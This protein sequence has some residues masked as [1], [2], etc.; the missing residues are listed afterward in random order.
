MTFDPSRAGEGSSYT[1][2]LQWYFDNPFIGTSHA[3]QDFAIGASASIDAAS[4]ANTRLYL[5]PSLYAVRDGAAVPLH[6]VSTISEVNID[7]TTVFDTSLSALDTESDRL[8]GSVQASIAPTDG[9]WSSERTTFHIEPYGIGL[10]S[11]EGV[12][13]ETSD[14]AP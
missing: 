13:D 7:L 1:M 5:V 3:A 9:V 2:T 11:G 10:V 8:I 14:Y 12:N 6:S 4:P